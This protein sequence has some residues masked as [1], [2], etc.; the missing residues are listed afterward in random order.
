MITVL[1]NPKIDSIQRSLS[2]IN[3]NNMITKTEVNKN[4]LNSG[5]AMTC[6]AKKCS[7]DWNSSPNT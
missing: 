7:Q 6:K 2:Q 3:T 1:V 4:M 5:M